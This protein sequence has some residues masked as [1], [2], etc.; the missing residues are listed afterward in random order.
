MFRVSNVFHVSNDLILVVTSLFT[1]IYMYCCDTRWV[2]SAV[3]IKSH[4]ILLKAFSRSMTMIIYGGPSVCLQYKLISR[5]AFLELVISLEAKLLVTL[6]NRT[7]SEDSQPI[8]SC[9]VFCPQWYFSNGC[10]I[11][12]IINF[13]E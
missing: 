3:Q 9:M 12:K 7:V 5:G 10:V 6:K 1:I 2:R 11:W 8:V 13:L 4:F